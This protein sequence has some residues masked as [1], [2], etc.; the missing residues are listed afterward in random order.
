MLA[1]LLSIQTLLNNLKNYLIIFTLS[2]WPTI[3]L[4][5]FDGVVLKATFF[6]F[7]LFL[8]RLDRIPF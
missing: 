6:I 4:G 1:A 5:N 7:V 8:L 2:T 3:P